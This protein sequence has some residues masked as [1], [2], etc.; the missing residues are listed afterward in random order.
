MKA[1]RPHCSAK[2]FPRQL[3]HLEFTLSLSRPSRRPFVESSENQLGIGRLLAV[4][5]DRCSI[6]YF[7]SPADNEPL[8]ATVSKVST[9]RVKLVEETRVYHLSPEENV[10]EVGRVLAYHQDGDAYFVGFPNGK[11]QLISGEALQVRCRLPIASPIDHLAFQLNETAFWH[12]ARSEF[13]R[14]LLDQHASNQGLPAL[15]SSSIELVP[16]QA[17]V[18]HRVLH[19]PFQRYLLAD[20]VGLGKTIEAGVLIRQFVLD[21]PE[22]HETV[23]IVPES[24]LSQWKQELTH[25][26]HLG[27]LIGKSIHIVSI[28][29]RTGIASRVRSSRMMV[30]D[31]A[32]HLCSWAWSS[33]AIEKSIFDAVQAAAGEL[34]RRVLLLSATPVLHNERSFLAM[35]HLLDPQ[36]YRLEDIQSFKERVRLRQEIAE[37]MADLREDESNFFLEDTLEVL[38]ELL[39]DDK[40]FLTQQSRLIELIRSDVSEK[41]PDRNELIRSIRTHVSDMWRLHRRILRNRRNEKTSEY[42]PGR[43]GARKVVYDCECEQGLADA[44]EAWRLTLSAALYSADATSKNAAAKLARS[45]EESAAC[46]PCHVVELADLRLAVATL[47]RKDELPICEGEFDVL[48]QLRRAAKGCNQRSKLDILLELVESEISRKSYVVFANTKETGDRIA[49]FLNRKLVPGTVLRHSA[50]NLVWTQ[51]KNESVNY[52]LVCDRSAEEGLN[53]QR[54]GVAAI[55]YDLPFSPNRIE[56][57]MGRLDRFGSGGR[58]IESMVL[59]C[60]ASRVQNA[61][62]DLLES[63]LAVFDRSVASL[64]YVIEEEM[65]HLW[66]QFLDSGAEA[67]R[68]SCGVLSGDDGIVAKELKRIRV[69]DD[70]DSFDSEIFSR[71]IGEDLH[72]LDFKLYKKA[73]DIFQNW[74]VRDLQFLRRGEDSPDDAVFTYEFTRKDDSGIRRYSGRDTLIPSDEFQRLFSGSIDEALITRHQTIFSTVPFSFDRV[75]AQKRSCRL[76]RIG[77]PFVDALEAFT[78]W[79]ERGICYAFWRSIDNYRPAEDPEVYFRFDYIVSPDPHPFSELCSRY[80]GAS[81]TA[82]MRRS[83]AIMKRRF[84]SIWLDADLERVVDEE[85]LALLEPPYNKSRIPGRQDFNLN[86][87]RWNSASS[88]YDMSL[89]KDRCFAARERSEKLLREQSRL[90]E[91]SEQCVKEAQRQASQIQQQYRSR[92]AMATGDSKSSLELELAFEVAF[93]EAQVEAF[94]NPEVRVDSVGAVFLSNQVPFT[95]TE[96]NT[97][98]AD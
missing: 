88:V 59:V 80:T 33:D 56:Q 71:G 39:S 81:H 38:S 40:E 93:F 31:E 70:L 46:D 3:R 67:I 27:A 8:E 87:D 35:L 41:D 21:E 37:R 79:D 15:V 13:V 26:F 34:E 95:R 57:R 77:D 25:R 16:H 24:L 55:H 85:R 49:A 36:V 20:E 9:K 47:N 69:Q 82:L 23:I 78:R 75:V 90:P 12:Q 97:E 29:D 84:T 4:N 19:D 86:R 6:Q 73:A 54:R 45:M 44:I 1:K 11:K 2:G 14:H 58:A 62:L 22:D 91:W 65:Q 7:R 10:W 52:V 61:W 51:F 92:L 89:W 68:E 43:G 74:V 53:L 30:I 48:Q 42:L 18:V 28:C 64:Q 72:V 66:A 98:D 96:R 50:S 60:S 32:H 76:L 63:G 94:R 17:A 5:G 83:W